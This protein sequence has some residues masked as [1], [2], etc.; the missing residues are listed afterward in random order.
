M[1]L[2]DVAGVFSRYFIVGFFLPVFFV[3]VALAQVLDSAML[4]DVYR[5]ASSGARIAILGGASLAGGLLLLGLHYNVLRLYEGYP[6]RAVRSWPLVKVIH[7]V[8][9]WLQ[10]LRY[11]RAVKK[12]DFEHLDDERPFEAAWQLGMRFPYDRADL[13]STELLLPTKFGNAVRAFERRPFVKWHLNSIGAWPHVE[14]L[15]SDQEAQVLSDARG[16]V[17]FFING[18]LLSAAAAVVLAVDLVQYKPS[19]SLWLLLIPLA[20]SFV[21]YRAAIGAAQRWGS[22]V[23]A[24]IDL[25]RHDVYDKLGLRTPTDFH[26]ERVIAWNLNRTL[27]IGEHLPDE[28]T[29]AQSLTSRLQRLK[30][31]LSSADQPGPGTSSADSGSEPERPSGD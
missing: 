20:L 5:S 26:D 19:S 7:V 27:L 30:Q 14:N 11:E 15:L 2:S 1:G 13:T 6:L 28:L 17:A 22:V 24:C 8:P 12:C 29:H 21:A 16:D 31:A 23:C 3:L 10:T 18:S 25:H 4:P 9:V